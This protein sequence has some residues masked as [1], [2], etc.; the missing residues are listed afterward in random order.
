MTRILA[1][2]PY[3]GL[4]DVLHEAAIED[5]D[6]SM[7][8][9]IGDLQEG[10]SLALQAELR[11]FDLI[12]SRGGTASL[13]RGAVTLPVVDI[14]V[15]GYDMLRVLTMVKD[16]KKKMGVVGFPNVCRGAKIVRDL[17]QLDF[18]IFQFESEK[19]VGDTLK[20][21]QQQG[22]E[23]ILGDVVTVDT[24]H[25]LGMIGFLITS[26]REAVR[27]ALA[28]AKRIHQ[29]LHARDQ[30]LHALE[31]D[32]QK[33]MQTMKNEGRTISLEGTLEEIEQ[34]ILQTILEEEGMNQSKAAARLGISRSTL[35]RKMKHVF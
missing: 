9:E 21:V 18:P 11:G 10:V 23:L 31:Q 2:A 30:K 7:R 3:P 19:Q 4:Y 28:E 15:S 12:I 22:V 34:R 17:L 33:F 35:W 14:Q 25:K 32:L 5:P 20:Q 6:I 8:I 29:L 26:G 1:I 24:A 16:S 27:E 13:I